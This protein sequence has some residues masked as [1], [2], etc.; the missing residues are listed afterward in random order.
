LSPT[1]ARHPLKAMLATS[2]PTELEWANPMAAK[3]KSPRPMR[4]NPY[5]PGRAELRADSDR[6]SGG[7]GLKCPQ[8]ASFS[9]EALPGGDNTSP[10]V[11]EPAQSQG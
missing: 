7:F 1:D 8:P 2:A 9:V 4:R 11:D 10:G 5:T 6:S 3:G